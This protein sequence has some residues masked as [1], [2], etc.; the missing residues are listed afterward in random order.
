MRKFFPILVLCISFL[1]S[2]SNKKDLN[3][4]WYGRFDTGY[5]FSPYLI[6]FNNDLYINCFIEDTFYFKKTGDIYHFSEKSGYRQFDLKLIYKGD[7][8]SVINP[9]NDS[10]FI[11]LKKSKLSNF[12]L[13]YLNDKQIKTDLPKGHG[14]M[15]SL[16]NF[17][18]NNILYF[19]KLNN[20][21]LINFND[22][23]TNFKHEFYKRLCTYKS[24]LSEIDQAK[25]YFNLVADKRLLVKE[26]NELKEL[27]NQAQ[28]FRLTLVLESS[29][30]NKINC[31]FT[32]IPPLGDTLYTFPCCPRPDNKEILNHGLIV[33][34]S[35]GNLFIENG[36]VTPENLKMKI[37][38]SISLD[39]LSLIV[40]YITDS[41]TY[42]EYIDLIDIMR[43]SIYDLRNEYLMN[44][45]NIRYYDLGYYDS[46]Y[47]ETEDKFPLRIWEID[48][49]EY[50]KI[51]YALQHHS[52]EK[53]NF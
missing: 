50:K 4:F 10:L 15:F 18:F 44:K 51:K 33:K 5:S 42:Q 20:Q 27:L 24:S 21:L 32:K 29:N 1:N 3:G 9:K 49:I 19:S 46:R 28:C 25:L 43:N 8:L 16:G 36:K 23:T 37:K 7:G 13:D 45:Y 41:S 22:T 31:F 2:C 30:Y 52:K 47:Q 17:H 12:F 11:T 14:Q 48:S 6:N 53:P 38:K 35:N 34:S 39:S 26:I 40:Y